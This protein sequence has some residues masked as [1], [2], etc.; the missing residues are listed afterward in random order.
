MT[1]SINTKTFVKDD[2]RHIPAKKG[3]VDLKKKTK[4]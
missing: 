3:S 2:T 4:V 1:I